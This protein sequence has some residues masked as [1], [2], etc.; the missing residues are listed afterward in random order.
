MAI[1]DLFRNYYYGKPEKRD[2]T[3]ADMPENRVQLFWQVFGVRRGSMVGLNL[4]YLLIWLPAAAWTLL[5]LAQVVQQL[6]AQAAGGTLRQILFTW[7]L[8]LFPLIAITGPF[9]A[10]ISLVTHRWAQDEHSFTYADF[11]EGMKNNWKQALLFSTLD[12]LVPLVFYLCVNFYLSMAARS[13]LFLLPLAVAGIAA[14]LWFLA[15][16]LVPQL[17]VSYR[18]SLW[19]IL[20]NAILMAM[21]ELP[22][23]VGLRILTLLAPIA[24]AASLLF[25]PNALRWIAMIATALYAMILLAFN[26][27][28]W[29]SFANFVGEKYLN[30]KIPGARTNIGLRP[31][32]K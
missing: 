17:I 6:S 16:P 8:I 18:Q 5:N 10:G 15:A 31:K 4:L 13:A 23:T 32:S 9:N 26:K 14:C 7:L 2:F 24:A 11:K 30:A 1:R 28:I 3:E 12:G 20:R 22:R 29:A 27:L 21:A 25:F 19:G